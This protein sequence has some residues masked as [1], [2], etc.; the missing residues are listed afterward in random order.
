[1]HVVDAE[2]ALSAIIIVDQT[3][4]EGRLKKGGRRF[5]ISEKSSLLSRILYE[6]KTRKHMLPVLLILALA[7]FLSTTAVLSR[8][9]ET[10]P[11]RDAA[12]LPLPCPDGRGLRRIRCA[13]T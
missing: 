13:C 1:L 11:K 9:A 10:M 7:A 12:G 3:A 4:P 5:D 8:N 6:K 2:S